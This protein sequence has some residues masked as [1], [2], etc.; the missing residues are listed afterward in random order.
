VMVATALV[1][2]LDALDLGFPENDAI[3]RSLR[4]D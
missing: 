1:E 4:I 2:A 3:K